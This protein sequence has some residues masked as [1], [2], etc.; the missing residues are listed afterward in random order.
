MTR[1]DPNRH[2]QR[3]GPLAIVLFPLSLIFR[4]VVAMRRAAYRL[5]LA[6]QRRAGCP[7]IV[8]GNITVG[9]SGKTPLVIWLSEWLRDQGLHPGIVSRGYG[10]RARHWPQQVR[11]DS[12]PRTVGDE[13]VLLAQRRGCPVC[14]GPDRPAAIEAL[15]EH[16]DC[17]I[18]ISDDG[19]QHFAMARDIEI[20]V[21]DGERRFGNGLML[22]AGPLR[23]PVSRLNSVDFV[24][25][26]GKAARGEHAMR[27]RRPVLVP[28][29]GE[30]EVRDIEQFQ[31]VRVR[32]IAGIGNPERFF[33]MLRRF[34]LE[35]DARPFPDHHDFKA[36]E[37]H[38]DDALPL[39]MTEKDAVK[40]RRIVTGDVWVVRVEAQ[41]DA[42]FV[43]RLS[44]TIEAL[45]QDGKQDG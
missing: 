33:G 29:S 34:G 2:W 15:L 41:P 13:A 16:T 22:P 19:L 4:A 23:E 21:V 28:L 12:D 39:L 31:G 32:A 18:V 5:G 30:G 45:T 24:I 14:V 43:H 38:F 35:V 27:L 44:K 26:N 37:L 6:R 20:A 9:G 36:V 11:A 25:T 17:N 1:L 8:V 40:C 3:L 7:V 42:P 10:G